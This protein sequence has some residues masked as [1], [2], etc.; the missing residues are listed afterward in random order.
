MHDLLIAIGDLGATLTPRLILQSVA[1]VFAASVLRGF[2]GFGFALAAVPLLGLFMSPTEAVPVAVGLQLAG[3]LLDFPRASKAC[4][5]PSLRWLMIGA[6]I[7]SPL[8]TLILSSIP[9]PVSRLV[10]SSITLLAVLV[11]G[12]GFALPAMPSGPATSATGFMAGFFNGLAAMPGPPVV[13]YYMSV[14]L[15]RIT[16][17]ASLMVFFMMTSI[18]A[19]VVF[20]ATGLLNMH[21]VTLSVLALPVMWLGTRIGEMAFTRG[22]DA[23]HRRVSIVSLGVIALVSAIKGIGELT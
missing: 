3:S 21:T 17:R 12:R 2:T 13:A 7:G 8:G 9:A 4:D 1:A 22:T 10:I 6:L 5:W 18:T 20:V 11:L 19:T 23:V 16:T 14:P 15:P